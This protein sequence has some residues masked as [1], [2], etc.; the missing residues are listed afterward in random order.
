MSEKNSI[1]PEGIVTVHK[2]DYNIMEMSESELK[3][4]KLTLDESVDDITRQ[5]NRA[6]DRAVVGGQQPDRDWFKRATAARNTLRRHS[7]KV[8]LR[9]EQLKEE[10]GRGFYEVFFETARAILTEYK[11]K[12]IE[13]V[14]RVYAR[15]EAENG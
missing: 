13:R 7:E 5:L 15:T 6:R 9:I 3:I 11:F 12:E 8:E 2:R 1:A 10:K 14:A 4:L